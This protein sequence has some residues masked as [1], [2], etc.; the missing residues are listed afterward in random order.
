MKSE[1]M[2]SK[3]SPTPIVSYDQHTDSYLCCW[4]GVV[5]TRTYALL[6]TSIV[7]FECYSTETVKMAAYNE[8]LKAYKSN[9]FQTKEWDIILQ[10]NNH[11]NMVSYLTSLI[12]M[13][14]REFLKNLKI[15]YTPQ[16]ALNWFNPSNI[17]HFEE[18]TSQQ[19]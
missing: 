14:D 19:E 13:D 7:W 17:A 5:M 6:I 12:V 18:D 16:Q 1:L 11:H 4:N 2:W 10:N 15:Q 8:Y 3:L 9:A